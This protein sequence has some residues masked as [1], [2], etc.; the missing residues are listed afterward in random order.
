MPGDTSN[1]H[2]ILQVIGEGDLSMLKTL[3]HMMEGTFQESGLDTETF[4]LVRIAALAASD[5][6]PASWLANLKAG[7]EAAEI[8]PERV[9][10]TLVAIAPVVGTA[11]IV[12][13]ASSVVR[14]ITLHKVRE[15]M[16]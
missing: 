6:A 3:R 5:A 1:A 2:E 8:D 13:A 10:G 9:V 16:R 11:R 7:N 15:R 14:A 4:M 12:S